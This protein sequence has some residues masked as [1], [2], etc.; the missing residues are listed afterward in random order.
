MENALDEALEKA[1]EIDQKA[2]AT[3]E[4]VDNAKAKLDEAKKALNGDPTNKE[5][6]KQSIE[7]QY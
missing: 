6:L 2:N 1:N 4:E 7:D 5:A 3:Q